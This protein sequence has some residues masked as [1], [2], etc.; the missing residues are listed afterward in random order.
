MNSEIWH[1]RREAYGAYVCNEDESAI[2]AALKAQKEKYIE[3]LLKVLKRY[4]NLRFLSLDFGKEANKFLEA[5]PMMNHRFLKE[6]CLT[7]DGNLYE[8]DCGPFF[9]LLLFIYI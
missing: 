1:P 6:L 4:L 8:L 7:G 5:L 9:L 2:E 3:D